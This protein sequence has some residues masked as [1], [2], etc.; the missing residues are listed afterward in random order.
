MDGRAVRR[1]ATERCGSRAEH[2]T[3][4]ASR[5]RCD[6]RAIGRRAIDRRK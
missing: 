3:A 4:L 1:A 6:L 5:A 2:G